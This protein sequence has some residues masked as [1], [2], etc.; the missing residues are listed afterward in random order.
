M[1]YKIITRDKTEIILPDEAG[2]ALKEHLLSLK[3]PANIEIGGDMYLS[4]QILSV[5][6]AN[7]D[8]AQVRNAPALPQG[9]EYN[10]GPYSIQR[11]I[12]QVAL[13]DRENWPQLVQDKAW[14]EK[15]RL[16]LRKKFPNKKW[17]DNKTNEH[18]CLEAQAQTTSAKA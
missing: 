2:L 6:K 11:V 8:A 4:S 17:C 18:A 9:P 16:A 3:K 15:T 7:L 12:H 13:R 1:S 14:R 5:T 10:C